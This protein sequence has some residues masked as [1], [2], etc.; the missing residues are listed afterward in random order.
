MSWL[1]KILFRKPWK[2]VGTLKLTI[3]WTGGDKPRPDDYIYYHL[4]ERNGQR[5]F[6]AIVTSR[7]LDHTIK[8]NK[9]YALSVVPWLAGIDI[10][11]EFVQTYGDDAPDPPSVTGDNIISFP[12]RGAA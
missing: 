6:E 2:L 11:D 7:L 3:N 12:P 1:R 4:Y 8:H 9:L 5:K 10:S